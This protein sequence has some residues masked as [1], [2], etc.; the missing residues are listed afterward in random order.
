MHHDDTP[1]SHQPVPA[2]RPKK[3][4]VQHKGRWYY[5]L[6]L[7]DMTDYSGPFFGGHADGLTMRNCTLLIDAGVDVANVEDSRQK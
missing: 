3:R 1:Q 5:E 4:L 7:P 6:P 2:R